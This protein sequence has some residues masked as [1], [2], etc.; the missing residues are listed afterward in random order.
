MVSKLT[1]SMNSKVIATAKK[2]AEKKGVSLSKL[3]EEYFTRITSNKAAK[4]KNSLMELK[5]ILGPVPPDFDYKKAVRD[6]VYEK[7][8]KR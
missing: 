4:T 8:V 7:H 5:G 1:L 2:Y 3:V 6:H